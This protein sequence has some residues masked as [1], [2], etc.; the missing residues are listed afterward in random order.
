MTVLDAA[1]GHALVL[2]VDQHSDAAFGK[3]SLSRHRRLA[4]GLRRCADFIAK[5]AR[6]IDRCEIH[7]LRKVEALLVGRDLAGD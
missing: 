5:H 4:P 1:R 6:L 2:G 3:G 7:F